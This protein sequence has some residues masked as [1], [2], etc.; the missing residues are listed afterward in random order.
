MSVAQ[1]VARVPVPQNSL[2]PID[3]KVFIFFGTGGTGCTGISLQEKL[4]MNFYAVAVGYFLLIK[5]TCVSCA[6]CAIN[7]YIC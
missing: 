1:G 4:C 7:K 5:N 2:H 3:Y 6:T